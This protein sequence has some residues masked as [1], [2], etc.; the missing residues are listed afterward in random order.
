M[1]RWLPLSCSPGCCHGKILRAAGPKI[2]LLYF[3]AMFLPV[4]VHFRHQPH[5]TSNTVVIFGSA[6][7][8]VSLLSCSSSMKDHAAGLVGIALG[9][10]GITWW[11]RPRRRLRP[12]QPDLEGYCPLP[13]FRAHYSVSARP[14]SRFIALKFTAVTMGLGRDVLLAVCGGSSLGPFRQGLAVPAVFR[15][16]CPLPGPG[17]VVLLGAARGQQPDGGHSN[18]QPVA[19]ALAWLL[20][21]NFLPAAR[22]AVIFIGIYFT[23]RG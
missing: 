12:V 21:E 17:L 10:A 11:S 6:P 3:P 4:P 9:F 7:I 5:H 23:R 8:M 20:L 2:L 15:S 19:V 22:A 14:L 16:D 13:P 18:L 1:C